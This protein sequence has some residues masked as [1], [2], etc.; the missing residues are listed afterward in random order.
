MIDKL[1]DEVPM[2][3]VPVPFDHDIAVQLGQ[4]ATRLMNIF[5]GEFDEK[6]KNPAFVLGCLI[7]G[8]LPRLLKAELNNPHLDM[9]K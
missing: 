4:L 1:D 2:L 7:E 9:M 3:L 5:P 6:L 8:Y